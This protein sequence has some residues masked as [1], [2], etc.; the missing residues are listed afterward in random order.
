MVMNLLHVKLI[1]TQWPIVA[2]ESVP[3]QLFA[4]NNPITD[5]IDQVPSSTK[6]GQYEIR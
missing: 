3:I 5:T 6:K 2:V 1:W 4:F